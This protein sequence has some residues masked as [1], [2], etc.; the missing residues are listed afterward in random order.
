[1]SLIPGLLATLSPPAGDPAEAITE[2]ADLGH[3][4]VT[5]LSPGY[6]V[7]VY[8]R[9]HEGDPALESVDVADLDAVV[10]IVDRLTDLD[11]GADQM[12]PRYAARWLATRKEI[13]DVDGVI[14]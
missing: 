12:W 2:W 11:P 8:S 6:R 10:A 1:M 9:L 5:P 13:G 14:R 4:V 7:A 3:L